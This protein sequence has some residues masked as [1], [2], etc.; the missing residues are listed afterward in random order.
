MANPS[1]LLIV[2][3]ADQPLTPAQ[4][5]FNQLVRK[6]EQARAELLAWQENVPLFGQAYLQRV[7]PLLADLAARR[8][9][10]AYKLD[11][12]LAQKGWNKTERRTMGTVICGVVSDLIDDELTDEADIPQLKALYDQ[13]AEVDFDTENRESVAAMKGLFEAMSG[14]DL[15]DEA[16]ESEDEMMQRAHERMRAAA[17]AQQA[18]AEQAPPPRKKRPT[19]AQ[20]RREA[21]AQEASQSVREVYRKLVSALHPDRAS[22]DADRATRTAQMKR[23]NRAY[24]AQDLLGLFALQLEIEQVDAA[25]LAKATAERARHYNQLLAAQLD[26]LQNEVQMRQTGF[27]MDYGI[28]L[29]LDPYRRLQP[30][31]LGKLIDRAVAELRA[32][33]AEAGRDLLQ[34]DDPAAAKRWLRRMR[35]EQ[36]AFDDELF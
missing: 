17:H 11:A 5:K 34:L 18:A 15:G 10:V 21:E 9:E 22:D 26:E 2:S 7:R 3:A 6:I 19:A 1:N 35:Q 36:Q 30:Q 24:E 31:L 25:H 27:V 16:F 23:V 13:H 14:V 8:R 29:G 4:R 33:L 32:E 28:E 20:Q 12:M